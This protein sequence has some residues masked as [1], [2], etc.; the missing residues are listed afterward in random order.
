[1]GPV[2][3]ALVLQKSH[4]LPIAIGKR[5]LHHAAPELLARIA[6]RFDTWSVLPATSSAPGASAPSDDE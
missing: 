2:L 3:N 1:M 6:L 4:L 5:A